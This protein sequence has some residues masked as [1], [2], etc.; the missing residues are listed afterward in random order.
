MFILLQNFD[1][2]KLCCPP[3]PWRAIS[4]TFLA[5]KA[6]LSKSTYLF[7]IERGD[8]FQL[9]LVLYQKLLL[10]LI[11]LIIFYLF[12]CHHHKHYPYHHHNH[13]Q[14]LQ[15]VRY[16]HSIELNW[17][18][19]MAG[20]AGRSEE[21]RYQPT[22]FFSSYLF[23]TFEKT[24]LNICCHIFQFSLT[25]QLIAGYAGQRQGIITI[26]L[27]WFNFWIDCGTCWLAEEHQYQP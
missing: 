14:I 9:K 7:Q 11:V 13:W 23:F 17:I 2:V 24:C 6:L 3:P 5:Q 20:H 19:L 4:S 8:K 22:I 12:I 15:I 18:E 10:L 21:H 27:I 26:F 16:Q 1:Q 25:Y